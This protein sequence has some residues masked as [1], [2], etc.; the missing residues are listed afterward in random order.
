V[1]EF[2]CQISILISRGGDS[3]KR[4]NFFLLRDSP[5]ARQMKAPSRGGGGGPPPTYPPLSVVAEGLVFCFRTV[6]CG[7]VKLVAENPFRHPIHSWP[8]VVADGDLS[9]LQCCPSP[10]R[11]P[12]PR[13]WGETS[14]TRAKIADLDVQASRWT[15]HSGDKVQS[16]WVVPPASGEMPHRC[17]QDMSPEAD[18][19]RTLPAPATIPPH[20]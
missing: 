3:Q 12:A 19:S 5:L 18:H 14:P 1:C 8:V 17:Q 4:K 2:V 7:G 6:Q 13:A 16:A 20:L 11:P 10:W 15:L 9:K